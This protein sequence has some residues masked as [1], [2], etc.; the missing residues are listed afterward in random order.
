MTYRNNEDSGIGSFASLGSFGFAPDVPKKK[1]SVFQTYER[2]TD[3]DPIP[4]DEPPA[5]K[6]MST[7]IPSELSMIHY[8]C[9]LFISSF[10]CLFSATDAVLHCTG[11]YEDEGS[12]RDR[13]RRLEEAYNVDDDYTDSEEIQATCVQV[14]KN[15]I[16]FPSVTGMLLSGCVITFLIRLNGS[17]QLKDS[18]EKAKEKIA[19]SQT[20]PTEPLDTRAH[21]EQRRQAPLL[22]FVGFL[23][24][25]VWSREIF[26]TMLNDPW[27]CRGKECNDTD[28]I[29]TDI[30]RDSREDEIPSLG[31]VN[32]MGEVG[33]NANLFYFSWISLILSISLCYGFTCSPFVH[34]KNSHDVTSNKKL[35]IY[36]YRLRMGTWIS[37]T[38]SCFVVLAASTRIWRE[39]VAF[40]EYRIGQKTYDDATVLED[41][42]WSIITADDDIPFYSNFLPIMFDRTKIAILMGLGGTVLSSI[43]ILAHWFVGHSDD[44]LPIALW[45]ELVLS[46]VQ[47]L[48]FGIAG[49]FVTGS[50]GPAQS[51]G[52][53][54]YATMATFFLSLR[55]FI[56]CVE[57]VVE[58]HIPVNMSEDEADN[59]AY[60]INPNITN[61]S[62]PYLPMDAPSIMSA[63]ATIMS[64]NTLEVINYRPGDLR[65]WAA[66]ATFSS[67]NLGSVMDGV[68]ML[69]RKL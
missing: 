66:I 46:L 21:R 68:S 35:S 11:M 36:S 6:T 59:I 9:G 8:W 61:A 65:R 37:T 14:F 28:D 19:G 30:F 24:C 45:I 54:Y 41:D 55:I 32:S 7:Y 60:K 22:G 34:N 17:A 4:S 10:M 64:R 42:L 47:F 23:S 63:Q 38:I 26:V 39:I 33:A 57:E 16:I 56:G 18:L 3:D 43:A 29:Q 69:V 5:R 44:A 25:I 48:L 20:I 51:V 52:V 53:L 49:W 40:R 2:R 50:G 62:S 31:A 58:A 13:F 27:R 12:N 67:L 1:K 15:K